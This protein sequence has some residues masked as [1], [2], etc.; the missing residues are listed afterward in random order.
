MFAITCCCLLAGGPGKPWPMEAVT[1]AP[2]SN[3]HLRET[4]TSVRTDNGCSHNSR[5]TPPLT[6]APVV[7]AAPMRAVV[8]QGAETLN[9]VGCSAELSVGA[10]CCFLLI[11]LNLIVA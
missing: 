10:A 1:N 5:A 4:Q 9:V 8:Q 11:F 3:P 2:R 6:T 7:R